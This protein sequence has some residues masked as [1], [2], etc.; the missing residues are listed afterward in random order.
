VKSEAKDGLL[1]INR[2]PRR[3]EAGLFP[4][5]FRWTWL[6]WHLDFRPLASRAVRQYTPVGLNHLFCDTLLWQPKQT[7]VLSPRCFPLLLRTSHKVQAVT[8]PPLTQDH[9]AGESAL[10]VIL[11]ASFPGLSGF[12][13][14][15]TSRALC[16]FLFF[17]EK[18]TGCEPI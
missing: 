1:H 14:S 10:W 7:N 4:E 9:L 18:G 13:G 2:K 11:F 17:T 16:S 8:S 5:D 3:D 15:V 6:F 12:L